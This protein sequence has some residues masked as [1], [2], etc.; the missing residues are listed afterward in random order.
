MGT[1]N[2]FMFCLYFF[3]KLMGLLNIKM[4]QIPERL[5]FF[6]SLA[7]GAPTALLSGWILNHKTNK[8]SYC[9]SINRVVLLHITLAVCELNIIASTQNV[10]SFIDLSRGS[11]S[12]YIPYYILTL[13]I[14]YLTTPI[15]WLIK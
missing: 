13:A 6:V 14:H 5:L 10:K 12:Y 2:I 9:T 15:V 7:G 1:I 4:L 8:D 11:M 3:D